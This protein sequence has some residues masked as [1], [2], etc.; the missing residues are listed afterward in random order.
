MTHDDEDQTHTAHLAFADGEWTAT[1]GGRTAA[2]GHVLARLLRPTL[3]FVDATWG[4]YEQVYYEVEFI[5]EPG[6]TPLGVKEPMTLVTSVYDPLQADAPYES[7]VLT[8]TAATSTEVHQVTYT[9]STAT[10]TQLRFSLHDIVDLVP[11]LSVAGG[12]LS[13]RAGTDALVEAEDLTPESLAGV[14]GAWPP[15]SWKRNGLFA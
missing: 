2:T 4:P 11:A 12:H 14:F 5:V 15:P 3:D 8:D 9:G 13:A 6:N 1:V 10:S 7:V